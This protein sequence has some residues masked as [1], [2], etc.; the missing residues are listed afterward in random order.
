[1]SDHFRKIII[2]TVGV[3]VGG[4][5]GQTGGSH[6]CVCV[7]R[8]HRQEVGE[9]SDGVPAHE[10]CVAGGPEMSPVMWVGG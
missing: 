3:V 6:P 7:N 5:A 2:P 1:M 10:T 4:L 8:L 9:A